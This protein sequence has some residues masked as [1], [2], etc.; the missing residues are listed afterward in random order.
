M[1]VTQ[2]CPTL[3]NPMNCSPPASFVHGIFQARILEWVAIPFSR[4]SF[5][6]RDQTLRSCID[7]QIPYH[8]TTRDYFPLCKLKRTWVPNLSYRNSIYLKTIKRQKVVNSFFFVFVFVFWEEGSGGD[9]LPTL[10]F[11][12]SWHNSIHS[13]YPATVIYFFL[14]TSCSCHQ[15]SSYK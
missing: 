11:S 2:L 10:N 6:P 1:L 4:G 7:R 3:C 9:N 15:H 5:W 14:D 12:S 13:Y 8:C